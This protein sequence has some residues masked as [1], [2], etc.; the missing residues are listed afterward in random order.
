LI[1]RV[2]NRAG[3]VARRELERRHSRGRKNGEV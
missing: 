3:Q 1:D 2:I